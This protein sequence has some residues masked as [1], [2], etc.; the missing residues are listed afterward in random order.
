[1]DQVK[2]NKI[3]QWVPPRSVREVRKF[4][5]FT[6]YYRYFIQGYSQIA[7]PLLDL[8]KQVTQWRWTKKEQ[9][10]FKTLRD[11]MM[12]QPVLQQPNFTKM[13][14]LQMDTSK[15]GVGAVLSQDG[16]EKATTP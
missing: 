7:R 3:K 15:Y 4:L 13:F 9:T 2:V 1:M 12:S 8:T 5:G 11:K 14:Y 10:A 16:E 6:G